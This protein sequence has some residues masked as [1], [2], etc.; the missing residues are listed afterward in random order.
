MS[1]V[2]NVR[3]G[4]TDGP[5]GGGEGGAEDVEDVWATAAAAT[6]DPAQSNKAMVFITAP[7]FDR[8]RQTSLNCDSKLI[9]LNL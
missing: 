3:P 7:F 1:D 4:V 9:L 6:T 5:N 2:C 8:D